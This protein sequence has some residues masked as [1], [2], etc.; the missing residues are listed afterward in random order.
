[1]NSTLGSADNERFLEQFRYHIVA[2]QLLSEN[3]GAVPASATFSP[4]GVLSHAIPYPGVSSVSVRG[5]IIAG[6]TAFILVWA[7][8]WARHGTAVGNPVLRA[9]AVML[10]MFCIAVGLYGYITRRWLQSL[11]S[12]AIEST[13]GFVANLQ[14][15]EGS[16][17]SVLTLI[18]EVELVSRGY[19]LGSGPVPPVSRLEAA[20]GQPR[21]LP[22]MRRNLEACFSDAIPAVSEAIRS[23]SRHVDPD[24]VE[25]YLDVYDVRTEDVEDA[26]LGFV[27]ASGEDAVSLQTLR[28]HQA[29]F[30]TQRRLF[31]CSLLA[32]RASGRRDD[33][34]RWRCAVSNMDAV[35]NASGKLAERLIKLLNDEEQASTPITPASAKRSSFAEELRHPSHGRVQSQVRRIAALSGNIRSL[36]AK[37]FLLR[38]ESTRALTASTTEQDLSE[39]SGSLKDQY[40][41]LGAD[42]RAMMQAWEAGKQ[43]LTQDI[44]RSARRISRAGSLTLNEEALKR[45]GPDGRSSLGSVS[46]DGGAS[47][48]DGMRTMRL[49]LSPPATE[50][51]SEDL[52]GD[53]EI[54]EA[55]SAAARVRPRSVMTRQERIAAMHEERERTSRL[56]ER[57]EVSTNMIKELQSVMRLRPPVRIARRGASPHDRTTSV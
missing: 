50:S 17:T 22:R 38:D 55:V 56:R 21:S 42:L 20:S 45:Y 27:A 46:E 8:D 13:T 19:R 30:T 53:D 10:L 47:G 40:E 32:L 11:R 51:G 1:M 18:Q 26:S 25:R 52:T 5:A 41:A 6:C 9:A 3:V 54:F 4:A 23:I 15:F 2:S 33:S 36:Q 43:A 35:G 28:I 34:P 24:E 12:Q 44:T 57:A 16:S 48:G 31:L 39:L 37:L 29:R 49:P 7:I 14:S